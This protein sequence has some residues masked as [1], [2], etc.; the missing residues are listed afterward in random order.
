MWDKVFV[1]LSDFGSS[2]ARGAKGVPNPYGPILFQL[3]PAA[4]LEASDVAVC[5]WSAGAT[6]FNR[7]REALNT[8]EE[9]DRLFLH[10]RNSGTPK[11][12]YRDRL[13]EEFGRQK[14]KTQD[15]EISCTV[16]DG[17]LSTQHVSFIRVDP[18]I[19][20]NQKLLYWVKY[21]QAKILSSVS[22][23]RA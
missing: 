19:I 12:K 17:V 9:V 15:P 3:R 7:Q 18:Y 14:T 22:C 5:L 16:P 1:N 23:L 8:P 20:N 6:G 10:P 21:N 4:L 13:A 11:I 2:F